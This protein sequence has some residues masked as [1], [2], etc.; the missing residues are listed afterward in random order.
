L[1][2]PIAASIAQRSN[3]ASRTRAH[4]VSA[5]SP[6]GISM[7]SRPDDDAS[8]SMRSANN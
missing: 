1:S 3:S 6:A 7:P 5:S 8:C 2:N 4:P